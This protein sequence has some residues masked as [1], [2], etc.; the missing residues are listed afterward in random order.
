MTTHKILIVEDE[1][2]LNNAYSVVL[3]KEGYSVEVAFN[4]EE[5]LE[6]VAAFKPDLIL[7]DLRMP[8]MSGLDF[9]KNY[10][11]D[12]AKIIVFSNMD[13]QKDIDEA[14]SLG[15]D[16]YVLKAWASPKE[17]VRLVHDTLKNK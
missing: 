4:G 2:M 6:K 1:L 16:K 8:Q 10:K 3:E 17:L 14:Y 11:K 5:A 15:A 7:L 12:T 9:L 13:V